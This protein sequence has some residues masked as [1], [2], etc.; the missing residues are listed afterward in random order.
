MLKRIGYIN[1]CFVIAPPLLIYKFFDF[2]NLTTWNW[3]FLGTYALILAV[4]IFRIV[5]LTANKKHW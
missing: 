3:F 1:L 4:F 5:Y 2:E